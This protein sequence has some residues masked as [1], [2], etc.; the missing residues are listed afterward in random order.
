MTTKSRAVSDID[1]QALLNSIAEKNF[2][3]D[4]MEQTASVEQ[5]AITV[6]DEPT[7]Q[8]D[9]SKRTGN[10]QR[11][12]ALDEFG[13]QFMQTPKI[14]NH[15]PVFIS[16]TIRD[17]LDRIVRLFGERGMSVSGL[18]ENLARNFLETYRDYVEQWRK[19]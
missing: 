17:D 18:M 7:I 5:T 15:K 14:E 13:Q 4:F 11:K 10:K 8:A 6:P 19:L 16:E 1:E 3:I 9:N 2:G 12:L